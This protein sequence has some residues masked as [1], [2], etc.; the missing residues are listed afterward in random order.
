MPRRKAKRDHIFLAETTLFSF[1]ALTRWPS[2][3]KTSGYPPDQ[4]SSR[5]YIMVTM[6]SLQRRGYVHV[7]YE[8]CAVDPFTPHAAIRVISTWA[9]SFRKPER[10]L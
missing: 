5:V 4:W 1:S 8:D 3:R 10:S 6:E 2:A 7:A 9:E